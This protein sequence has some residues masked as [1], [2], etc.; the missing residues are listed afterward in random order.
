MRHVSVQQLSAFI[1]SAL[2]GVSRELVTRHLAACS[3]CRD[4]HAA[5]KA[6]DEALRQA[7][8]WAPNE[9]TLEGWSSRVEMCITAERKGLPVPEFTPTLLPVIAPVTPTSLP[10]M[11]ELLESARGAMLISARQPAPAQPAEPAA[12]SAPDETPQPAHS[13]Q[14]SEPAPEPTPE[15]MPEPTPEPAPGSEA[16]PDSPVAGVEEETPSAIDVTATT[17]DAP[18]QDPGADAE[19]ARVEADD[20]AVPGETAAECDEADEPAEDEPASEP[21]AQAEPEPDAGPALQIEPVFVPEPEAPEGTE[22]VIVSAPRLQVERAFVPERE[23]PVGPEPACVAEADD[24]LELALVPAPGVAAEVVPEPESPIEPVLAAREEAATEPEQVIVATPETQLELAFAH[25]PEVPTE[26]VHV[27]EG[28]SHDEPVSRREVPADIVSAPVREPEPVVAREVQPAEASSPRREPNPFF[29]L[30]PLPEW[31]V[32]ELPAP[33]LEGAAPPVPTSASTSAETDAGRARRRRDSRNLLVVCSVL[34][35]V[36]LTSQF[37][38]EVIRIPLPERWGLRVPRVEFVRRGPT[39]AEDAARSR[40]AELKL[41]AR[42]P[43]VPE[44]VPQAPSRVPDEPRTPA[45][46]SA[47]VAAIAP[48]AS[49]ATLAPTAPATSPAT[50]AP[51]AASGTPGQGGAAPSAAARNTA[52]ATAAPATAEASSPALVPDSP[53]T[54]IPVRV[55]KTVRLANP[56]SRK[57]P[58]PEG[59]EQWPLLCGEVID[60]EGHPVEGARVQLL[61]FALTVRTDRRGRFCVACPPG[62]RA[63]RV[64]AAGL[65]VV[66]RTVEL[67]G[68]MVETRIALPPAR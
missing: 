27:A 44:L 9:R 29:E 7:L 17:D 15:P 50:V 51:P 2:S 43:V 64:E 56:P 28:E 67:S 31:S 4:K 19:L 49:E 61:S 1:D 12:T 35:L 58:E 33:S 63:L 32:P 10:R 68:E 54:I 55:S 24:Q 14:A 13:A 26:T 53:A 59:D 23:V 41:A 16:T 60:S 57:P 38:P 6:A 8:A 47:A 25:E 40:A 52:T 48:S 21:E 30:K 42:Q 36:L 37:M 66:N 3:A 5:W 20:D 11:R 62:V 45:D 39:P 22:P 46:S 18:T 34:L 65:P